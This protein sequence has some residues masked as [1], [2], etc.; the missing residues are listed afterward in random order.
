M[1][2]PDL[3]ALEHIELY[4]GIKGIPH[5]AMVKVSEQRL[6][7]MKLWNVRHQRSSEYSGGMKRRLSVI[8][9]TLG[10]PKCVFLDEARLY[11]FIFKLI[12]SPRPAWIR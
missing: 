12:F 4:C 3:T 5:A 10:D 1:L 2:Y 9:A 7:H 11:Q 6:N 8:L